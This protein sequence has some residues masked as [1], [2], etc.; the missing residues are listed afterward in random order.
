MTKQN[1]LVTGSAGFIFSNFTRLYQ[2]H[3]HYELFHVDELQEV[4][5]RKFWATIPAENKLAVNVASIK[6]SDLE[7]LKIDYVIH[8]AISSS[9]GAR[10]Q[11]CCCA[12]SDRVSRSFAVANLLS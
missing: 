12:N 5:D 2:N 10:M 3:P 7:R 6:G 4:S 1:I 9:N 11:A 8:A